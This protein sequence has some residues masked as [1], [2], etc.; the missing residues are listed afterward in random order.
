[1]NPEDLLHHAQSGLPGELAPVTLLGPRAK[2]ILFAMLALPA[3]GYGGYRA[4]QH[5]RPP[6][7]S[8]EKAAVKEAAE[9][10]LR[11]YG[12]KKEALSPQA[13]NMLIGAGVG[14]VVGA[15]LNYTLHHD[16]PDAGSRAARA[17]LA[18]ALLGTVAG[19]V[20]TPERAANSVATPPSAPAAPTGPAVVV[21]KAD[22]IARERLLEDQA[23]AALAKAKWDPAS[24][25]ELMRDIDAGAARAREEELRAAAE[26]AIRHA[27]A[28][29]GQRGT[30]NPAFWQPEEWTRH[31]L[32]T[33]PPE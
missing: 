26:R 9:R 27:V 8:D 7:P 20:L 11:R 25:K 3:A 5:L 16:E 31:L 17:G 4:Y 12:L 32:S 14:G 29:A 6:A 10:T 19:G 21:P 15:G 33:L 1:M 13:R 2:R 18:G 24:T 23:G 28:Q 22:R 30:S